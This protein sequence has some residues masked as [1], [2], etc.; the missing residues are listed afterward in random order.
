M[1]P[2]KIG[3]TAEIRALKLIQK[4]HDAVGVGVGIGV[5]L[6]AGVGGVVI[7]VG[8]GILIVFGLQM[9]FESGQT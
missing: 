7:L 2:S 1:L 9:K 3:N 6:S 5:V 4:Q 8:V